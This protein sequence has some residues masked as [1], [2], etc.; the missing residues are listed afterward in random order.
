MELLVFGLQSF[1]YVLLLA[2]LVFYLS[3]DR[4][5]NVT[6]SSSQILKKEH[7]LIKVIEILDS[8]DRI[9]NLLLVIQQR[10]LTIFL[11]VALVYTKQVYQSVTLCYSGIQFFV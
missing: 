9:G 3:Y 4:V 2:Y 8:L 10:F 1:Y 7:Q 6:L 5:D 11:E